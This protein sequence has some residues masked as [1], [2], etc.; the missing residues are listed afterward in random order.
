MSRR[1]DLLTAAGWAALGTAIVVASWR[2]DRLADRGINPWSVPGLTPGIVGVLMIV[3]A[4]VLAL[5]SAGAKSGGDATRADPPAESGS[6]ARTL[7]ALALCLGFAGLSLG[8]G[9]PFVV[10]G[11]V[12]IV[13]FTSAF[14]WPVWREQRRVVAGLVQTLGTAV[15]AS[16]FVSWLFE[17]VFLVRLP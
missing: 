2:M 13:V 10:E 15:L 16:A 6:I 9:L 14:S 5:Q 17:S 11:A 7:L 12:F 8:H 1:A 4:A 3:L